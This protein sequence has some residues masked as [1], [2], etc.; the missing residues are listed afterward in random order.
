MTDYEIDIRE[1][2]ETLK[3]MQEDIKRIEN[4][5]P[6]YPTTYQYS[7]ECFKDYPM[8]DN[9]QVP[10]TQATNY[11]EEHKCQEN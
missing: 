5:I 3:K 1:I 7:P 10:P 2:K 11:W 8:Y 4:N 9:W 6:F